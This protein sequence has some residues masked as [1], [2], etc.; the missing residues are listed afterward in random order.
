MTHFVLVHGASHGAW[1]WERVVPLLEADARVGEVI[2]VDLPGHGASRD[3]KPLAD[4]T[5]DD[6]VEHV[7]GLIE[8][9]DLVDVVIVGHSLAGLT[10]PRVAHRVEA[11]LRRVVYMA[12]SNPEKGRTVNDLMD[13]PLSPIRRGVS[14]ET[15]FCNDLDSD[16]THWLMSQLVDEPP[17]LMQ[18]PVEVPRAP[19]GVPSTYI[20]LEQDE[21]LPPDY[22][23]EQART[24]GVDEVVRFDS[25][26]SAFAAKPRELAE[27]LLA[28][29]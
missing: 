24:A 17:R 2:A 13:H 20:L 16:T 21:T 7:A 8:A 27:L 10:L 4:I 15:M 28:Y 3:V 26:H 12:S 14:M 11:R 6:Y 23:R 25:G 1:C 9:R 29:A 22:Q 19:A 18:T 5:L